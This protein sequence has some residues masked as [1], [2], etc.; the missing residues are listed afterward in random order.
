MENNSNN[1]KIPFMG[2]SWGSKV[3][4]KAILIIVGD[5]AQLPPIGAGNVL[6]DV[7]TLE[8]A[9]IVKLTKI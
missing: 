7:L 4:K 2:F 9:P 8:L 5:D 6:S 3:D 1:T